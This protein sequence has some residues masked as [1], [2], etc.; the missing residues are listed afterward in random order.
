MTLGLTYFSNY[1]W[2]NILR[3][4]NAFLKMLYSQRRNDWLSPPCKCKKRPN[5]FLQ[6]VYFKNG[7][8]QYNHTF[9]EDWSVRGNNSDIRLKSTN[10]SRSN[11]SFLN[12]CIARIQKPN[13]WTYNFVEVSWHNLEISQTWGFWM[14]FL[15]HKEG[16]MFFYQVFLLSVQYSVQ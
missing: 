8:F 12:P 10:R 13:S 16:G 2:N 3:I 15:N 1:V 6:C 9:Y 14:D 5:F 7:I 4:C 11:T